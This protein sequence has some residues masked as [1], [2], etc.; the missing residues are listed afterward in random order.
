MTTERYMNEYLHYVQSK[1]YS[2]TALDL[3]LL[4]SFTSVELESAVPLTVVPLL[5]MV[6]LWFVEFNIEFRSS[7]AEGLTLG[8]LDGAID[9]RME[10]QPL[11]TVWVSVRVLVSVFVVV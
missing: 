6:P 3:N 9:G 11:V 1:S 7:D 4:S 5:V 10:V 8:T 2:Q